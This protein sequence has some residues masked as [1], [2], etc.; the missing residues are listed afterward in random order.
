MGSA[1]ALGLGFLLNELFAMS[2]LSKGPLP[3]WKGGT[4]NE[5]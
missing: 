2:E 3:R 4:S 1:L 5:A